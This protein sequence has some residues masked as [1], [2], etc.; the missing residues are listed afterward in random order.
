LFWPVWWSGPA[1]RR[2]L[3]RFMKKN[4]NEE[5]LLESLKVNRTVFTVASLTDDSDD[6]IYWLSRTPHERLQQIEIL[7]R[8]NYGYNATARLQRVFELAQRQSS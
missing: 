6:R 3:G 7:R 1:R 8:I 4:K 5:P 2:P